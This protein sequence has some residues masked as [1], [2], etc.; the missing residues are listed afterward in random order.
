MKS[1]F[2]Q[3]LLYILL[4]TFCVSIFVVLIYLSFKLSTNTD[5]LIDDAQSLNDDLN[6]IAQ[7]ITY[8]EHV[9][10]DI[11]EANKDLNLL[12]SNEKELSLF[13]RYIFNETENVSD[14][15]SSKSAESVN[16]ALTRLLPRLRKKCADSNIILPSSDLPDTSAGLFKNDESKGED[17]SFGFS[18]ESYDGFWP[19]FSTEEARSLGIQTEIVKEI[20]NYL[21]LST[22]DNHSVAILALQR[23]SVGEVDRSNIGGDAINVSEIRNDLLRDI[24]EIESY[25]FKLSIQTQTVPLRKL[26]NKLRPPFLIREFN[27]N[28]VEEQN[29]NEFQTAQSTPDPFSLEPSAEEKFLPIVSKV[30]SKVD[31][32]LEY[33]VSSNRNLDSLFSSL[34]HLDD[35]PSEILFEW[36]ESAGHIS[37]IEKAREI[38]NEKNNRQ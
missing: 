6:D 35:A 1:F 19:S 4:S 26:F 13:L 12:A 11:T 28:P 33:V 29:V 38:F 14:K 17:S 8:F 25:I 21:S 20:V 15:W 5:L 10:N 9:E 34:S 2:K 31:L 16:A 37:L 24:N 27:I 32:I 30:D 3:N 23:E 22:D 7:Q 18:F 36:L